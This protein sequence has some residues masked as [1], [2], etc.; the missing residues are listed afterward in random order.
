MFKNI[1]IKKP[2]SLDYTSEGNFYFIPYIIH[3]KKLYSCNAE[4]VK[5]SF[6]LIPQKQK[7]FY[8]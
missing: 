8:H 2:L 5:Y 1:N 3:K 7:Y 4:L 6:D